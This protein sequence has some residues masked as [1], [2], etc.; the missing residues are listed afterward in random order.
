VIAISSCYYAAKLLGLASEPEEL[1]PVPARDAVA[2][3]RAKLEQC[4][5]EMSK[6]LLS[7][8][9][10]SAGSKDWQRGDELAM[11]MCVNSCVLVF[12]KWEA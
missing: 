4:K 5:T 8:K 11:N 9:T 1:R 12:L 6:E 2:A 3:F 10:S 7:W